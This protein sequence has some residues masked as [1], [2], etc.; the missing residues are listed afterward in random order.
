MTSLV[1]VA[2]TFQQLCT[3]TALQVAPWDFGL[4]MMSGKLHPLPA[5]SQ[6][7]QKGIG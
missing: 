5:P 7:K 6:S 4:G 1:F 3:G 2:K